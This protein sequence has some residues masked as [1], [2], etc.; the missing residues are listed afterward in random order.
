VAVSNLSFV[1]PAFQARLTVERAGSFNARGDLLAKFFGIA[2]QPLR[3]LA[4]QLQF[5]QAL[6]IHREHDSV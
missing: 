3:L 4:E 6:F 1:P 2:P 5:S